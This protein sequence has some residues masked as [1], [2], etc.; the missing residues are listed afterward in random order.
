[1]RASKI[2]ARRFTAAM[3]PLWLLAW[4]LCASGCGGTIYLRGNSEVHAVR[5]GDPSPIDGWVISDAALADLME[6]CGDRLD[7]EEGR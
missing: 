3:L 4:T 6:C 1:M 7:A 5:A 2:C